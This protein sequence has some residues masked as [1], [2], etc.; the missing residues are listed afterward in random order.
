MDDALF[1]A[2]M[3]PT[4]GA[5]LVMAVYLLRERARSKYPKV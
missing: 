3:L 5:Q 1:Y 4:I 2:L